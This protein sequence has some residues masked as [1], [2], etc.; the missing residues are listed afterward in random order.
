[1][2]SPD[3]DIYSVDTMRNRGN[4]DGGVI[5]TVSIVTVLINIIRKYICEHVNKCIKMIMVK[6]WVMT[7]QA[8]KQIK[9]VKA[10]KQMDSRPSRRTKSDP[11]KQSAD[12][13][14]QMGRREMIAREAYLLAEQRNFRGGDPVI[15]WLQAEAKIDCAMNA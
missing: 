12:L 5:E 3:E 8:L 9:K 1:V 2:S 10:E 15:D 13:E 7:K 11:V 14:Q 6:E 4:P